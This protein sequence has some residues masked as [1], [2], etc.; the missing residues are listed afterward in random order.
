MLLSLI[1]RFGDVS[2]TDKGVFPFFPDRP[3]HG[4]E[5]VLARYTEIT[6]NITLS[7][8]TSFAPLIQGISSVVEE[9]VQQRVCLFLCCLFGCLVVWLFVCLFVCLLVCFADELEAIRIVSQT[10]SYHILLIIADGQVSNVKVTANAI[11]EASNYPMYAV[12]FF[13]E[14]C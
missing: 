5:E 11:V 1:L 12:F 6:P 9:D 4:V 3:C 14:S 7:G 13:T 2:T 8:P 10:K